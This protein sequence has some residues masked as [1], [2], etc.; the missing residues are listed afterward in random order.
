MSKVASSLITYLAMGHFQ[1][2][3]LFGYFGRS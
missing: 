3:K 2:K 1:K